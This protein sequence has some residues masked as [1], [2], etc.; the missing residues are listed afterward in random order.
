MGW[1]NPPVPWRELEARLSG[2]VP[3]APKAHSMQGD[4][5]DSPSWSRHRPA[6]ESPPLQRPVDA[7]PYAEL[8]A[9]SSFSHL[10]GASLPEE[11]VEAA[12]RR[13]LSALALTDHNGM[14]GVGHR[15]G[16][17][18]QRRRLVR[19]AVPRPGDRVA[20]VAGHLVVPV[21]RRRSRAAGQP[22]LQFPPRHRR[23][24]PAHQS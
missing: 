15:S 7:V 5:G 22:P 3:D 18:L 1:D 19:R 14:Y 23:V 2:R 11:L 9:H 4:G 21:A 12:A 13:G 8:H 6:Y 17:A 10:D 16:R 24:L 20:P